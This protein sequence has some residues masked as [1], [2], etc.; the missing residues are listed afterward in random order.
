VQALVVEPGDVFDDGQLQLGTR[1]P[2]PVGDQLGL[3]GVVSVTGKALSFPEGCP[4]PI[5]FRAR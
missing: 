1:A 2:D 4:L 5:Q 3:E